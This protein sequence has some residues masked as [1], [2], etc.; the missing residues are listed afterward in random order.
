MLICEWRGVNATLA[1]TFARLPPSLV[2]TSEVK[3]L[4]WRWRVGRQVALTLIVLLFGLVYM[5][6]MVRAWLAIGEDVGSMLLETVYIPQVPH[7][8]AI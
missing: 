3:L 2:E 7:S 5:E 1:D 6:S 8:F 4:S